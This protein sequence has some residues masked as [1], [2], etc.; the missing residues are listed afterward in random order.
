VAVDALGQRG[1]VSDG[2]DP[3]VEV[4]VD[5]LAREPDLDGAAAERSEGD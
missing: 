5:G 1:D 4:A 2:G 3:L